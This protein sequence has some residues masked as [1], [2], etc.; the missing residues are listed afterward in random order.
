MQVLDTRDA[1]D[2][3]LKDVLDHA[4]GYFQVHA[5]QRMQLVNY[6]FLAVAFLSTAYAT[7]LN[8]NRPEV[9]AAVALTGAILSIGFHRIDVRTRELVDIAEDA[10]L[11]VEQIM[12]RQTGVES[13]ALIEQAKKTPERFKSYSSIIEVLHYVT[14]TAFLVGFAYAVRA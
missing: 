8:G 3:K 7:G 2:F 6:F 5:S 14:C 11:E 10:L 12:Q 1:S 4:W 13:I 9:S